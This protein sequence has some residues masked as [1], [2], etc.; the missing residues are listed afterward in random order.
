MLVLGLMS[1]TSMDGLDCCLSDINI[2]PNDNLEFEIIDSSTIQYDKKTK[3]NIFE[4]ISNKTIDLNNLDYF[5]GKI[6][7]KISKE[8]LCDRK[9][10]L[11]AS[12]G[13]TNLYFL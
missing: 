1:G 5:L 10:E 12:H 9:I 2:S 8:F 11:I 3:N 6:F 13:Q 7:L 4:Y